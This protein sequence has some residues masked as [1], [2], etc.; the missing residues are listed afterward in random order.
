[1]T[2]KRR[3]AASFCVSCVA[4]VAMLLWN[5]SPFASAVDPPSDFSLQ[6]SP[7][8]LVAD[9]KPGTKTTRELK[10]RNAG[11][12]PETL[13]IESRKFS[14]N[15][16]T[17]QV[18]L[19]D[20]APSEIAEWV[21]F[22]APTFTVQP[23]EWYT[24]KVTI[25]LP[26]NT[27][28]SYS[29]ALI[30]SRTQNPQSVES[31]RLIKGSV[32]VFTLINVDRPGATRKIDVEDLSM[33]SGVYEYLPAT[34]TVRFKNTGNTIVQP[35]GNIFIQRG[36]DD[37]TPIATLPVNDTRGYILPDSERLL[38]TN[39]SDGFPVVQTTVAA[40]G[41]EQRSESWNWSQVSKLRI[42]QYTA[43]LVAVYNDGQRD[44]PIEKEVTFWVI[45]WKII[46][47]IIVVVAFVLLGVWSVARKLWHLARK[48]KKKRPHAKKPTVDD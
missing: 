42:G 12:G 6:V 9:L 2:M 29:L 43:K 30:I 47:G 10:I 27:G 34:V 33:T 32:A 39:W 3:I 36:S 44:V 16:E 38:T 15:N 28:F 5:T 1:M 25:S 46:L 24:Q 22:S 4:V 26:K 18:A 41:T 11:T 45:P 21:K 7:S 48:G 19:D 13:K 20:T 14:V 17:G 37:T 8:P 23:G 40:D 31:G 35:Y